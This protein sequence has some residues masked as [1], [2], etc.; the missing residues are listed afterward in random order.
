MA[1]SQSHSNSRLKER[2]PTSTSHNPYLPNL[3]NFAEQKQ[4]NDDHKSDE[5]TVNYKKPPF[6]RPVGKHL[7]REESYKKT[8]FS[9]MTSRVLQKQ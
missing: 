5:D 7:K 4:Q 2:P 9:A 3:K 8:L 6:Q 1:Q